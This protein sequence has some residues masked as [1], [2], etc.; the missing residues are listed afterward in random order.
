VTTDAAFVALLATVVDR[1]GG[2]PASA[3][4]RH[5]LAWPARFDLDHVVVPA[6]VRLVRDRCPQG[7]AFN[8]LL[9][10]ARAHLAVRVALPLEAPRDWARPCRI[11]CGCAPCE[12]LSRFLADPARPGW[13]LRAAQP[14]RTHIE[15]QIRRARADVDTTTLRRGSPH[16]LVCT[17]NQASH[18]RRVAQ[19]E[20]DLAN[21]AA[22][23]MR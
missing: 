14:L 5:V 20:A 22:L 23:Q 6:A 4:G 16:S 13:T 18:Q 21:L 8:A 19:R 17:K 12:D 9:D 7:P 11:E 2:D 15:M 10:A 1:I 3:A